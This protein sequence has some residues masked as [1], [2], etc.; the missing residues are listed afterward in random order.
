MNSLSG[1][2][3]NVSGNIN[4]NFYSKLKDK[5]SHSVLN[6]LLKFINSKFAEI[7]EATSDPSEL[8][9]IVQ[10]NIT[11]FVNEFAKTWDVQFPNSRFSYS[12]ICDGFESLITK[13]L[14]ARLMTLIGED[15]KLERLCR[16]Y[17]FVSLK[18]LGVDCNVDEFELAT[19]IKSK[20]F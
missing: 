20:K 8:S 3:S 12:E 9:V 13:S 18:Q 6:D 5:R 17:A 19:Q 10:D 4:I 7:C 2:T 1:N 16:K 11:K 14:Y 15:G